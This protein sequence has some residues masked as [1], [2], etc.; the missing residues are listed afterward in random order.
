MY[1]DPIL[2]SRQS[3]TACQ[4]SMTGEQKGVWTYVVLLGLSRLDLENT[5]V[6]VSASSASNDREKT[7]H[8]RGN[9]RERAEWHFGVEPTMCPVSPPCTT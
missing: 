4:H 2:A 8:T 5:T 9:A 6:L 3:T 1:C 7:G